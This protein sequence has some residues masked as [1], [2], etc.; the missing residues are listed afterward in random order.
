MVGRLSSRRRGRWLGD[1]RP[2]G[3]RGGAE[4][5]VREVVLSSERWTVVG[6]MGRGGDPRAGA[7]TT[8]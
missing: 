5:F 7:Y 2:G 6:E 3:G 1:S 4:T 8:T